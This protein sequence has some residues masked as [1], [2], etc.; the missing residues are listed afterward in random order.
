MN[1][2]SASA[3]IIILFMAAA[4]VSAE[5]AAGRLIGKVNIRNPAKLDATAKKEISS[6][7]AKIKKSK[8][9]GAV[10]IIGDAPSAES[11]DEYG[12]KAVFIARNV[13]SY[14]KTLL[15]SKFQTF[16]MA[17]K[18]S[19]TKKEA[20]SS[21]RIY[22]YPFELMVQGTGFIS[23]QISSEDLPNPVDSPLA[24]T[25]NNVTGTSVESIP[26]MELQVD[27][28]LLSPP[29]DDNESA[30]ITSKKERQKVDSEN[31]ALANEMVNRAKARAAERAKQLEQ[32]K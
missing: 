18:F 23:S 14:L 7:S 27:T 29:S 5:P 15:S 21:A 26:V 3:L 24:P 10:I 17:S 13:E 22:L 1:L 11:Q 19:D 9:S 8:N 31:P 32:E 2:R 28:G 6:I 4:P 16:I 25:P 20:S 12:V 30:E